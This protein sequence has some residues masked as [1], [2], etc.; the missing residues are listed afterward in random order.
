[1]QDLEA[2]QHSIFHG[3]GQYVVYKGDQTT[4]DGYG[5]YLYANTYKD[6]AD[7]LVN[8]E[9]WREHKHPCAI[10]FLYR[11]A[12]ELEIKYGIHKFNILLEK[13]EM[14]DIYGHNLQSLWETFLVRRGDFVR[15]FRMGEGGSEELHSA[16]VRLEEIASFDP[17]SEDSRYPVARDGESTMKGILKEGSVE[18]VDLYQMGLVVQAIFNVLSGT[19]DFWEDVIERQ[20]LS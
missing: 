12:V 18:I 9:Y 15:N 11:Q 7:C 10:A 14:E 17:N 13:N 20:N 4:L 16:G 2:L 8:E 6:A 19:V 1:M 3:G 5:W